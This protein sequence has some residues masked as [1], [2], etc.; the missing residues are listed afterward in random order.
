MQDYRALREKPFDA[1]SSIEMGEH[2]GQHNYPTYVSTLYAHLK[3]A[4]RLLLQQMSRRSDAAPGGGAFIENYI[5]PDMHMRPMSETLGFLERTGFEIRD[6][7]ALREH[8]VRT[9]Y[10]WLETFES[11]YADA[12]AMVGEEVA[13]V[14]R[15]YLVG[16]A[17]SF[18]EGRMGVDQILAVRPDESGGSQM[19]P[20]PDWVTAR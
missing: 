13:R 5:A 11:H 15:L 12:V 20:T 4:G 8:Y 9:V 7:Q 18:E 10:G 2:V 6:V 3:P 14:W 16:G 17:L 1:V 19:P